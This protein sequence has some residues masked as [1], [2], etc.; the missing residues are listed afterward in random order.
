MKRSEYIALGAVGVLMAGFYL[1]R[2]PS[3]PSDIVDGQ[4]FA[5][6]DECRASGQVPAAA[7]EGAFA[8]ASNEAVGRAP[9]FASQTA[10]ELEYGW[11]QCRAA[12]WNGASVFVPAMVGVMVARALSG[13][14]QGYGQP[15]Y[16]PR[17][18]AS[19]CPQGANTPGRPDC[20]Q[21]QQ[22]SG[23]G[24]A[25]SRSWSTGGGRTVSRTSEG[26]TSVD[27]RPRSLPTTARQGFGSTGRSISVSS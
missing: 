12:S 4:A 6:L 20:A 1:L 7:C 9:Q 21:Q 26:R 27:A 24:W 25:S 2:T 3:Q 18:G 19:S 10:C 16:P 17:T 15:L 23:G 22:R 13:S 8:A 5:S 11:G 14:G